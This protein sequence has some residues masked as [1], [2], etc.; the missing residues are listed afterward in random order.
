MSA[1]VR[2]VELGPGRFD[3]LDAVVGA[4][5]PTSRYLRFHTPAPRPTPDVREALAAVDGRSHIAVAAFTADG[6]PVGIARLVAVADGPSDLAVEVVDEWQ[7]RGIGARLVRSVVELGR[8]A[9]HRAVHADVLAENVAAQ[10]LFFTVFPA[11]IAMP[12]AHEVGFAAELASSRVPCA[13]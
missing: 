1:E 6:R 9:G 13:A 10:A 12:G 3:V 2:I 4:L 11:A 8:A 7:G 5:S